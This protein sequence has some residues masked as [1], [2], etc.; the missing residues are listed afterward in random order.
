LRRPAAPSEIAAV[1]AFLTSAEAS[2]VTGA[3]VPVD[4]GWLAG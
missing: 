1:V 3:Y 4:G 2:Y